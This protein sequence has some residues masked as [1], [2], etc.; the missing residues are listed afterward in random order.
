MAL[1]RCGR[2]LVAG[3][4][5]LEKEVRKNRGGERTLVTKIPEMGKKKQ[6]AISN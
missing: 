4:T 3:I 1:A 5:E 6:L 2:R